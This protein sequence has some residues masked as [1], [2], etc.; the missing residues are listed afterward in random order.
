VEIVESDGDAA[1]KLKDPAFK[2]GIQ[3]VLRSIFTVAVNQST[4]PSLPGS[5]GYPPDLTVT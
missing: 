2:S 5:P 3:A 1:V 4:D